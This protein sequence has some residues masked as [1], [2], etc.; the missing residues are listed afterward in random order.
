[1]GGCNVHATA[2]GHS[3][4][5]GAIEIATENN[6]V[7][8]RATSSNGHVPAVPTRITHRQGEIDN[9]GYLDRDR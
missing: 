4:L 5:A 9:R 3:L 8:A 1:M 2:Y 7:P 6:V